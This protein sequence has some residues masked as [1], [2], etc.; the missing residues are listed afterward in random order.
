MKVNENILRMALRDAIADV[1]KRPGTFVTQVKTTMSHMFNITAGETAF[2]LNG[3]TPVDTMS[4]NMMYKVAVVLHELI[5]NN[6]SDFDVARLDVEKYYTEDEKK[7]YRK[8]IDR[9]IVDKDIVF[10]QWIQIAKD[11]YVVTVSNKELARLV[12]IDKIHYNPETQRNLTIIETDNGIIKKVTLFESALDSICAN[13]KS[14]DYISDALTFNVNPDLYATPRI[15]GKDLIVPLD[16]VID[17]IDGYHRLKGAVIVTKLEPEWEQNF[18]IILTAFD[19]NKAKKYILQENYKNPLT[20]EQVTEYDPDDAANFIIDKLKDSM[21][22]SDSKLS[23]ISYQLNNLINSIFKP[24]RLKSPEAKQKALILFKNIEKYMNELIEDKG[25]IG[26][27][28]TVEEW[29]VYLYL[30]NYSI[31]NS[32]EFMFIIDSINIE[33]LLTQINIT[34]KPVTVHYKI[35]SEVTKNVSAR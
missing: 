35:M 26:K 10:K 17:C 6:P 31:N 28:F 12:A 13:M 25:Y 9:K 22:L 5:G 11:Q 7:A 21:Y 20:D 14:K 1:E 24:E 15:S 23:D 2:I 34:K 29:F 19:V 30:I 3:R 16:S 8:K 18:I 33:E 27:V 4:D 32:S